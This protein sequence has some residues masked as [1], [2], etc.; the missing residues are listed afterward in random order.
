INLFQKSHYSIINKTRIINNSKV[1]FSKNI[2][3]NK[4]RKGRFS[5]YSKSLLLLMVIF[6]RYYR[7]PTNYIMD[8]FD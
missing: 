6:Y 1:I 8:G 2:V 5:Y 7:Y 4:K 3:H